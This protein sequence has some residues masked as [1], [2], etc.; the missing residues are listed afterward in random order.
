MVLEARQKSEGDFVTA[1]GSA[2]LATSARHAQS[3]SIKQSIQKVT[4]S[5][6]G[7]SA[8]PF[9]FFPDLLRPLVAFHQISF[10]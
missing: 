1:S 2:M 7:F 3:S 4:C 6:P 9:Q 8:A 5:T 10:G